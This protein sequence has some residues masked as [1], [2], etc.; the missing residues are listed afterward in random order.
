[1]T[2]TELASIVQTH[3]NPLTTSEKYRFIPTT[4]VL[5]VLSDFGWAPIEAKQARV[6][7]PEHDGY[8]RHLVRLRNESL[9]GDLVEVGDV[10]PEI[11][12]VNSNGGS[13]SFR[14]YASLLEKVCG[15]GLIVDRP[16]GDFRIPHVGYADSRV[17]DA[18]ASIVELFPHVLAARA[19]WQ[20]LLLDHGEQ[21]KFA[22]RAAWLRFEERAATIDPNE[23]LRVRHAGQSEPTLWNTFNVVQEATIRGGVRRRLA[24][25]RRT[26]S[27]EVN[28]IGESIRLNRLLW[29]LAAT[30]A[31][32][33]SG[34]A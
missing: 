8:Q 4:Q 30:T 22:W 3:K 31:G 26:T 29:R 6:Y 23:L 16:A 34:D 12:V 15:N 2:A 32:Q 25:G 20:R 27:R 1:M 11:V 9:A 17:E 19:S 24:D 5:G 33:L 28:A 18:I 10:V 14:L 13:S 7:N 21:L